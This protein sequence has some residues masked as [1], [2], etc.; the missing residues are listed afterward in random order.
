MEPTLTHIAAQRRSSEELE[1]VLHAYREAAKSALV[2]A[3]N[4][5][6]VCR[7]QGQITAMDK[8]SHLLRRSQ[9][10]PPNLA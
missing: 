9:A 8:L 5:D 3:N 7:L 2:R 4:M 1:T 10:T 6:E